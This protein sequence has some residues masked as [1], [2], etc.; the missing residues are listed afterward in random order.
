MRA[1]AASPTGSPPQYPLAPAAGHDPVRDGTGWSDG[2]LAHAHP[3]PEHSALGCRWDDTKHLCWASGDAE[4]V[5][6]QEDGFAPVRYRLSTGRLIT[7]YS[8]RG[9]LDCS[10]E[11]SS[12]GGLPT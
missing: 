10:G 6:D 5:H 2:A 9:L 12:W 3:S 11:G 4:P 8:L 1:E 7:G